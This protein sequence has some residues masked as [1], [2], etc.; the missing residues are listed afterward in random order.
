MEIIYNDV[1]YELKPCPF[2]GED[3]LKLIISK[4]DHNINNNNSY[5]IGCRNSECFVTGRLE[6]RPML[7]IKH[8][9]NRSTL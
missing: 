8:W 7:A 5:I 3:D 2:C 1:K 6:T 4:F 9:N